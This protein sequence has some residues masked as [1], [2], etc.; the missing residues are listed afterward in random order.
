MRSTVLGFAY[1]VLAL[2]AIAEAFISPSIMP[3]NVRRATRLKVE[4]ELLANCLKQPPL[5][6]TRRTK[7]IT[8]SH[9]G[10]CFFMHGRDQ[11]N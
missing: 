2:A 11:P 10:T 9:A 4:H 1:G 8:Y 6:R 5:T 7:H 3:V